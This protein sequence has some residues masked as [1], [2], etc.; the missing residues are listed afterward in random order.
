MR[1]HVSRLA[2]SF[3]L[4]SAVA[5]TALAQA[6]RIVNGRVTTQ[7]AASPLANTF[8]TLAA[9]Q[10]D[11]GWIAYSV[12]TVDGDRVMCC[13]DSGD[14][15]SYVSGSMSSGCSRNGGSGRLRMLSR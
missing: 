4:V 9:A 3:A 11:A 12:T 13:F 8:R 15:T 2:A 14:G 10:A 1:R 7:P 5:A 6:P